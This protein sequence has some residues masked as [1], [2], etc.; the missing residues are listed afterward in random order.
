MS[1]ALAVFKTSGLPDHPPLRDAFIAAHDAGVAYYTRKH[2]HDLIKRIAHLNCAC[3][4][5]PWRRG[6]YCPSMMAQTA[7]PPLPLPQCN[8]WI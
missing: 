8:C 7:H 3:M 6:C 1:K 2:P 5:A 4:N